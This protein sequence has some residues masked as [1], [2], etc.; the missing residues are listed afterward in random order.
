MNNRSHPFQYMNE[1]S[2]LN[3][4]I[5]KTITERIPPV[6]NNRPLSLIELLQINTGQSVTIHRN[7]TEIRGILDYAG[8]DFLVLNDLKN[9]S[10]TI[11]MMRT[12]DAITFDDEISYLK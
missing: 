12:I 1:C 8:N 4:M 3:T 6:S 11:Y 10:K 7:N 9:H 5:P 2:S